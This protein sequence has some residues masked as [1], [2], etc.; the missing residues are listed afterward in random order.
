MAVA[1]LVTV[2]GVVACIFGFG[3]VA[4][5]AELILPKALHPA[6]EA[7]QAVAGGYLDA[8]GGA[9]LTAF[10]VLLYGDLMRAHPLGERA[11]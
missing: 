1:W 4:L 10:L 6:V 2:V 5:S 3:L 9:W 7:A 8:L 11:G